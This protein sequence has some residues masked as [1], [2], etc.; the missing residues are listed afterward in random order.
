MRSRFSRIGSGQFDN[1][2]ARAALVAASVAAGLL[3]GCG[4]SSRQSVWD[5]DTTANSAQPATPEAQSQRATLM[6]E[7]GAAW[8][9]RSDEAQLRTAIAKW[10]EALAIEGTNPE[11]WAQL[12]RAYY[13]L[14]DGHLAFDEAKAEEMMAT[15]EKGTRAA[16]RG[17]MVSSSSF[18]TRMR[19]GGKIE[20]AVSLIDRTGAHCLYWRSAN[21]GKWASAQGFATV[22]SYK[23]EIKAVMTRVLELDAGYFYAAPHRYFGAFFARAPAY[24]GGDLNK[25]REHF[26]AS[27][28]VEPNYFAT[29]V[30]YAQDYA[31]KAQN[32]ALFNEQLNYVI[33]GNPAAVPDVEPENRAEQRKARDL[34]ARADDL[35]E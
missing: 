35:F 4:G 11:E 34:M 8:A 1:G 12:S 25:S 14:A 23:D 18:A 19:E 17:L 26:E 3:A 6:Q 24:A 22:L 27:I 21:L 20:E 28:R 5:E 30:L 31:V 15:Y 9:R 2:R 13:F 29:R 32:R 7:A 10:E 16:E 33:N